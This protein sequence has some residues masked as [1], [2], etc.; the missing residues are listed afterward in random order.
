LRVDYAG[1]WTFDEMRAAFRDI[2]QILSGASE[3]PTMLLNYTTGYVPPKFVFDMI[4][5][6]SEQIPECGLPALVVFVGNR[7]IFE[8]YDVVR[9]PLPVQGQLRV[10]WA[11]TLVRARDVA[12]RARA[13]EALPSWVGQPVFAN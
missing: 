8:L 10:L 3:A 12:A 7:L 11:P 1:R 13:G 6:D 4:A 9:R 2:K 5:G